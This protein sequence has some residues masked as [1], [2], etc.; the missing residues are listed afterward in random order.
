MDAVIAWFVR[1]PVAAN[2]LMLF[3]MAAGVVSLGPLEREV[4]PTAKSDAATIV[5]AYP[6]AGPAEVE[7]AVCAP[8]E[9]AVQ[10]VRGVDRVRSTSREGVGIVVV[11]MT[12]RADPQRVLDDLQAELDR[13]DT[14][15]EEAEEPVATLVE[16]DNRVLTVAVSGAASRAVLRAAAEIVEDELLAQPQI[17]RVVLTAEPEPEIWI[18]LSEE[19]LEAWSLSF[20]EVAAAVRRGSLDLPA[21]GLRTE[22]G[23]L[24]L[25]AKGQALRAADF[26]RLPLRASADGSRLTVGDVARVRESWEETDQSSRLDGEP[27]VVLDVFRAHGQDALKMKDDVE[28]ALASAR[29]RLPE[30]LRATVLGDDTR[31]LR[32]RLDLMLRN[33]RAGLLLVLVS[34][35]LFLRLRLAFWVTFGIPV[36]LLGAIALMP[37]LD[38]S[39][40]L[41]S[42]FAFILVL[43]IVVDDAIVVAENVHRLR[44]EGAPPEE[45]A[46]R[47]TQEVAKPVVFAVLTTMAAFAPMVALPGTMGQYARNVP[48][49]VIAALAFSLLES[50]FVLP[51]HLRHLQRDATARR[52]PWSRLQGAVASALDSFIARVYRPL[53]A[54]AVDAR[55]LTVAIGCALLLVTLGWVGSGRARFNF[56]PQVESDWVMAEVTMPLGTAPERTAEVLERF[57]A[58]A[59]GLQQELR[60]DDG[61]PAILYVR[62]SLGAQPVRALMSSMGGTAALGPG[63]SGAH[64][65][66]VWIE[67]VTAERRS[68]RATEVARRWQAAV[69]P[70]PGAEEITVVDDLM[71]SDGDVHLQLSGLPVEALA[72]AAA[73]LRDELAAMPGVD[74]A[75]MTHRAGK[76]ELRVRLSAAGEA[77]GFTLADLAA[78]TRSAF[79][80]LEAQE[81]QRGRD[82]V[83]VRLLREGEERSRRAGLLQ[84]DLRA[85]DGTAVP[86]TIAAEAVETPGAAVIEREDRRRV[87]S[88]LAVLD[89][90]RITP[91]Q[92]L[93]GLESGAL[94]ALVARHPGL[95]WSLEGS[96]REQAEFLSTMGRIALMA[97]IAIYVLLAIPLRS[98]VQPLVIMTAIPFGLIGAV[99]GHVLLGL[100]LTM[101]SLIGVIALS[102]IVVNDSLVMMD[103]VNRARARGASLREAA[104]LAG[105][106][107][108]VAILLTS[109]TTMAGLAPLV[110]ERSLQAQFLIPMAVS[111][112]AG[113]A[114]AT[115]ITLLLVPA[116][117]LGV[118]DLQRVLSR[119]RR[120]AGGAA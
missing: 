112:A 11:E 68:V 66:E 23:H 61:G 56:F 93:A 62:S 71:A 35:A 84:T 67:L 91:D 97:L 28:R 39:I 108:M 79:H 77:L 47:G 86:F 24:L 36:T 95:R 111:V 64:L 76:P 120:G 101:F 29:A 9:E 3:V 43:G 81:F 34:L 89:K 37:A 59:R 25:R 55:W 78:Q 41:I 110:A 99:L 16:I 115:L 96:Q 46:I 85:P 52:G 90:A 19:A 14:L 106:R 57:E 114:F 30:G 15:P 26:E 92:A 53:L 17:S 109:L 60:D 98:Y 13:L 82:T 119:R 87:V 75:R 107:R 88:V 1:N 69:G 44:Q 104:L 118:E 38:V 50:L 31:I 73:E 65:G 72:L 83:A 105:P 49:I 74:S 116:L 100:D 117:L 51:S 18:E 4:L 40:N 33:G 7:E 12:E 27:A 63:E 45:A 20:D 42:L 94:P 48:L 70:V 54:R 103:F 58:A 8:I 10:G 2:L 102:G 22:E 5:T 6:G 113:V 21:G 80:G 32:D